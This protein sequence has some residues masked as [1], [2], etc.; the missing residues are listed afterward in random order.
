MHGIATF[1]ALWGSNF[2]RFCSEAGKR[3][4]ASRSAYVPFCMPAA[5]SPPPTAAESQ[6]RTRRPISVLFLGTSNLVNPAR[7]KAVL[8]LRQIADSQIVSLTDRRDSNSRSP[9]VELMWNATFTLCPEGD[10]PE[11]PRIYQAIERGSIPI[12]ADSFQR[13]PL[14]DWRLISVPLRYTPNGLRLPSAASTARMQEQVWKH[15]ETFKCE[16]RNAAFHQHLARSLRSF[17]TSIVP[18]KWAGWREAGP[19]DELDGGPNRTE[20]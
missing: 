10:M 1:R 9:L 2:L 17:D 4:D 18:A 5:P 15:R 6:Q 12:V 3:V 19:Q 16:P 14:A 8:A 20:E 7:R 13:P 11:S